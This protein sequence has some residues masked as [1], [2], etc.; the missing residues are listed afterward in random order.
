[1]VIVSVGKERR[2]NE[3]E[4]EREGERERIKKEI[5]WLVR[6]FVRCVYAFQAC[7]TIYDE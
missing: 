1:M 3:K 6:A 4:P 5:R 7:I 2:A